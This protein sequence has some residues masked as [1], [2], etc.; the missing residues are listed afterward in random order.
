[1]DARIPAVLKPQGCQ[2]CGRSRS[3]ASLPKT[4]R[5][6]PGINRAAYA[7]NSRT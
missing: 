6:F 4:K 3:I 1:M 7:A 5:A 2:P